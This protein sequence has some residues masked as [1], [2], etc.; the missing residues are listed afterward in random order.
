M[1]F[2]IPDP[3]CWIGIRLPLP[4]LVPSMRG[5][6]DLCWGPLARRWKP[7]ATEETIWHFSRYGAITREFVDETEWHWPPRLD[8]IEAFEFKTHPVHIDGRVRRKG[9]QSAPRSSGDQQAELLCRAGFDRVTLVDLMAGEPAN[10][11]GHNSWFTGSAVTSRGGA[12]FNREIRWRKNPPYGR[13]IAEWSQ[14]SWKDPEDAG[15]FGIP[16]SFQGSPPNRLLADPKVV[17]NRAMLNANLTRIFSRF[18]ASAV[19]FPVFVRYCEQCR[20]FYLAS[21]SDEVHCS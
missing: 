11:P 5:D 4:G 8:R 20:I 14:V 2:G 10:V 12:A 7:S 9:N 16:V 18:D 13:V 3:F 1:Q 21:A 19:P 6:V 15:S 17:A